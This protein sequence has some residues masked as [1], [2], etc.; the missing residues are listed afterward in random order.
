MDFDRDGA[1]NDQVQLGPAI[2]CPQGIK[3]IVVD[4]Y[5]VEWLNMSDPVEDFYAKNHMVAG[6][7]FAQP[8]VISGVEYQGARISMETGLIKKVVTVPGHDAQ[9]IFSHPYAD[10]TL[11]FV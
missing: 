8:R 11:T 1:W 7:V 5:R 6:L 2:H 9:I 3:D 4:K 10:L